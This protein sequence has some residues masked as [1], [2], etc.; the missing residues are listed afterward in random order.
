MVS[1]SRPLRGGAYYLNGISPFVTVFVTDFANQ[2]TI[3]V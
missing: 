3:S 1:N 2:Q